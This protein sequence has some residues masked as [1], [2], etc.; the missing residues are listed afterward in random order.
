[1]E[2]VPV[3]G[4][5]AIDPS[6]QEGLDG[7]R[8]LDVADDPGQPV[9]TRLSRDRLGLDQAP[10]ALLEEEGIAFRPR[11]HPLRERNQLG[12]RAQQ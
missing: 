2:H 3:F 11:N 1:M 8:D 12:F 5:Q 9:V 10:D 7:R 6:G 4:R